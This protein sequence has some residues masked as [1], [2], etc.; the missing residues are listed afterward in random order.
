MPIYE[1]VCSK[2][3]QEFEL[4]VRSDE[5]PACPGCG[6]KKLSKLISMPASHSPS[7]V[8]PPGCPTECNPRSAAPM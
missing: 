4:L 2:C 8:N 3:Q 6:G 7:G 5:T 1:Y